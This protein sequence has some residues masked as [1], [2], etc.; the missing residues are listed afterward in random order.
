MLHDL[1]DSRRPRVRCA[2]GAIPP[3]QVLRPALLA[4]GCTASSAEQEKMA[5]QNPINDQPRLLCPNTCVKRSKTLPSAVRAQPGLCV[6]GSIMALNWQCK[7]WASVFVPRRQ[8]CSGAMTRVSMQKKKKKKKEQS[9][10]FQQK[11]L[12]RI[13][14]LSLKDLVIPHPDGCSN[15]PTRQ[16]TGPLWGLCERWR[17]LAVECQQCC[18]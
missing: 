16:A 9:L 5:L 2:L 14:Y 17:W 8:Q 4:P 6:L 18:D 13:L 12:W 1:R 7:Q 3:E 11:S 10:T 15:L